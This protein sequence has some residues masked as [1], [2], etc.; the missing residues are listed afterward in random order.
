[1]LPL[2]KYTHETQRENVATHIFRK[3]VLMIVPQD[4]LQGAHRPQNEV[5]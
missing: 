1:M 4:I 2:D 3:H 5:K